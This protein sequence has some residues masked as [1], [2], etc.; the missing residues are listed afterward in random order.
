MRK[1]REATIDPSPQR[2][3]TLCRQIRSTWSE[4][5]RQRRAGIRR[6]LPW[7]VPVVHVPEQT[8]EELAWE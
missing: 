2:I 4:S 8:R 5:E 7:A 3:R 6:P 1:P